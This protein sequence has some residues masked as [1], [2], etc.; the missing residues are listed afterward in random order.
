MSAT[1]TN[2][3]FSSLLDNVNL[4]QSQAY[5]EQAT[6]AAGVG[7]QPPEQH[8]MFTSRTYVKVISPSFF[9]FHWLTNANELSSMHPL[10]IFAYACVYLYHKHIY[11]LQQWPKFGPV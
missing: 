11:L 2:G 4:D 6:A 7:E 5:D 1:T 8:P 9:C 10:N 3:S